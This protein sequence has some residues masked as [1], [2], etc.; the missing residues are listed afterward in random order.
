MAH[1][2]LDPE[3]ALQLVQIL[4]RGV[5][6]FFAGFALLGFLTYVVFLCLQAFAPR[7]RPKSKT[8]KVQRPIGS[9][10]LVEQTHNPVASETPPLAGETRCAEAPCRQRIRVDCPNTHTGGRVDRR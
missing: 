10:S 1:S 3:A 4:L 6:Y 5:A 8:A 7:P 2:G 9:T